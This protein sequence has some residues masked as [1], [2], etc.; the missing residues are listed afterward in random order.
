L[1][2]ILTFLKGQNCQVQPLNRQPGEFC[3]Q[4][5]R[6]GAPLPNEKHETRFINKNSEP[7]L[8]EL[9]RTW[10]ASGIAAQSLFARF[11]DVISYVQ[12]HKNT[13]N[14]F[15]EKLRELLILACTELESSWRAILAANHYPAEPRN[16][17]TTDYVKLLKPLRL[18]EW[19]ISFRAFPEYGTIKPFEGWHENCATQ[20]LNWYQAYH[21]VKH[22]R[23]QN[24]SQATLL[25]VIHAMAAVHIIYVAR[26]GFGERY[27]EQ[28]KIS[29]WNFEIS[30]FL[31]NEWSENYVA[32]LKIVRIPNWSPEEFY[33]SAGFMDKKKVEW[34][35]Q[36]IFSE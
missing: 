29:A 30:D 25:N 26:F 36:F 24:I 33:F 19:G 34:E 2:G 35:P 7:V 9:R 12:P 28:N 10:I 6:P 5:W 20:S 13:L 22:D 3:P 21:H 23:D 18:N 1:D 4:V 27:C 8:E 14:A 17:T 15:G 16:L 32:S 31:L 11:A